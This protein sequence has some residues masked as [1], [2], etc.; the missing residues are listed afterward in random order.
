MSTPK[1]AGAFHKDSGALSNMQVGDV[2]V[3]HPSSVLEHD[4]SIVPEK[5]HATVPTHREAVE[6]A[7]G[8]AEALAVDAWVTEDQI[9]VIKLSTHR[10]EEP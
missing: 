7:L 9:H 8:E 1:D 10:P 5:P 2:L 6:L 3:A 4:I